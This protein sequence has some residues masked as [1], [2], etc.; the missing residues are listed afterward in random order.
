[1]YVY[2]LSH[3]PDEK[4]YLTHKQRFSYQQFER[5]CLE[6]IAK[7][8]ER[9]ARHQPLDSY[10]TIGDLFHV[11]V[12]VLIDR[13]GFSRLKPVLEITLENPDA[14]AFVEDFMRLPTIGID[15]LAVRA[16]SA[17]AIGKPMRSTLVQITETI[18]IFGKA[19][20]ESSG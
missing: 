19:R 14:P 17:A 9:L 2:L 7:A 8:V 5:L 11:V 6:S 15:N 20:E 16:A 13:H 3:G 4:E 18:E 1:M 10:T 12:Q